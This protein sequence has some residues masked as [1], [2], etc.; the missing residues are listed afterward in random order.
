MY[1]FG[2]YF[3]VRLLPVFYVLISFIPFYLLT[4][5]RRIGVATNYPITY[6]HDLRPAVKISVRK[7]W[8]D[9]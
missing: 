5:T 2:L 8:Y 6:P 4:R 3:I 1:L 7:I 9:E